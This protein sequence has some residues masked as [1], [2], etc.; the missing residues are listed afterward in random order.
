MTVTWLT[1]TNDIYNDNDGGDDDDNDGGDDDDNDG[2]FDDD[3]VDDDAASSD[4]YDDVSGS[5][6]G[7]VVAS[8][9]D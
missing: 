9:G 5:G 6:S 7:S 8:D 3:D 1:L 4:T 2:G